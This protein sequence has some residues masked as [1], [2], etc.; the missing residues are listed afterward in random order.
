VCAAVILMIRVRTFGMA[1]SV[2]VPLLAV[3]AR[4]REVGSSKVLIRKGNG[5][6]SRIPTFDAASP[7]TSS[8]ADTKYSVE[9]QINNLRL[10]IKRAKHW[11]RLPTDCVTVRA[12]EPLE[13]GSLHVREV[14]PDSIE[15]L[16]DVEIF[17]AER[18]TS[19]DY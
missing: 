6:Q 3:S 7:G 17:L 19:I 2:I 5:R 13:Q 15:E 4:P 14:R 18:T 12:R 10:R 16:E 8:T 9:Q 1:A 11:H